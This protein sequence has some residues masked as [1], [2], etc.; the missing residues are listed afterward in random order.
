MHLYK[1]LICYNLYYEQL[2][3]CLPFTLLY[4]SLT[5]KIHN[6]MKQE[7]TLR[8]LIQTLNLSKQANAPLSLAKC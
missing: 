4:R 6:Q 2:L 8:M 1:L 3:K 5:S 7:T